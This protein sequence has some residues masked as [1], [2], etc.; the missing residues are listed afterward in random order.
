MDIVEVRAAISWFISY[1]ALS[2]FGALENMSK[3][4]FIP[5]SLSLVPQTLTTT[6]SAA[7]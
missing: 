6:C 5:D 2:L 4:V 3:N 1:V 7:R